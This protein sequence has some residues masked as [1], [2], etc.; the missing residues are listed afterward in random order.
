MTKIRLAAVILALLAAAPLLG[1]CNTT[2]GLGQ[3]VSNTGKV[4]ERGAQR[5]TP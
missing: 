4:I 3:D 2:A 1:A 5:A